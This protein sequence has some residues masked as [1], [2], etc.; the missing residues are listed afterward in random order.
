MKFL[1]LSVKEITEET[2]DTKTIHFWHPIHEALSYHSGQFLTV[3][4]E[5]DGKKHVVVI[6]YL[7]LP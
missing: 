4:P 5:I 3:I 2:N 1:H 7:P 6:L